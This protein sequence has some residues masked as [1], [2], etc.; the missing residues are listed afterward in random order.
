MN[1]PPLP[2]VAKYGGRILV[3][4]ETS[5]GFGRVAAVRHRV[6]GFFVGHARSL[7]A[8][9]AGL[10][11]LLV[12]LG[13]FPAASG[14]GATCNYTYPGCAGQLS[15]V[16][17]SVPQFVEWF[18]RLVAMLTGYVILGNAIVLWRAFP[19]TRISRAAWLAAV[20]L[21][22]QVFVG[23]VTVTFAE[24]FPGGYAPPVQLAHF[25]TAFA[26]LVSLVATVVWVD[27]RVGTGAT[28]DRLY[29]VAVAGLGLTGFQAVFARDLVFT[30]WPTIQTAYHALG[31]VAIA[32][33]VTAAIWSRDLAL[34]DGGISASMGATI[35]TANAFLVLGIFLITPSI[36]AT[37]Y[38][39]LFVQLVLF[40][41]LVRVAGTAR[42]RS[43]LA[44]LR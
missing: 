43:Y 37:T 17:L 22:V 10:T 34:V 35:G 40:G 20:L 18:H 27:E 36:E 23:G 9:T 16:G 13:E 12:L 30:F 32:L 33:F 25:A 41:W 28:V 4:M 15:P 6:G 29:L 7:A 8:S 14:A 19:G 24:L 3:G 1:P 26:I 5:T 2:R 11:F 21:P 42:D 39:L 38:L 44:A 31:H